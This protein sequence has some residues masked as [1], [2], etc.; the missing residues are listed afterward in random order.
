M[1][2]RA[3]RAP[4][5]PE[6]RGRGRRL[7]RTVV[8]FFLLLPLCGALGV[9]APELIDRVL[10]RQARRD[11]GAGA[12]GLERPR[13][14]RIGAAGEE[15]PRVPAPRP[16][17]PPLAG[18]RAGWRHLDAPLQVHAPRAAARRRKPAAPAARQRPV[19]EAGE[20]AAA[21][22]VA[23]ELEPEASPAPPPRAFPWPREPRRPPL[24][25]GYEEVYRPPVPVPEPATGAL[26]A[27][28]L[29]WLARGRRP[30]ASGGR[31]RR[32]GN[33]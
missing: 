9:L 21:G 33:R 12:P 25:D 30:D 2:S 16:P 28:A 31:S 23:L 15:P 10:T 11:P 14:D 19:A 18:A 32:G 17:A 7:R 27:A 4:A 1:R 24:R 8:A 5:E 22:P 29:A 20:G 3:G 13:E 6:R 26:L